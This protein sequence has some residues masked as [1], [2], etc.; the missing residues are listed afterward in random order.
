MTDW[1]EANLRELVRRMEAAREG[2]TATTLTNVE[3]AT[4]SPFHILVSCVISLRTKDEV[5]AEA[6]RRLFAL[7]Q[8]PEGLAALD[9]ESIAKAIYPAGFY[10]TKAR[11]L[12]RIARILVEEHGGRVPPDEEA[13]LA[14]PGVGRA[15]PGVRDS[16]HLRRYPRAPDLQ[17]ARPRGDEDA[18]GHGTGAAR[19]PAPGSLDPHQRSDGH[20][21]AEPVPPDLATVLHLPAGRPL[22]TKGR[23]QEQVTREWRKRHPRVIARSRKAAMWRSQGH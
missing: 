12:R 11:Q 22:R 13:L 5:T 20:L 23:R 18:R 1:N 14:L 7:A 16:R 6:S 9:E 3:R 2:W 19:A 10:N 21:R 4:R 17:P 15:G 8:T